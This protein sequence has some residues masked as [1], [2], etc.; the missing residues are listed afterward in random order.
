MA[1]TSS[2]PAPSLAL[3]YKWATVSTLPALLANLVLESK[4]DQALGNPCAIQGLS[5]DIMV[6]CIFPFLCVEEIICLRRVGLLLAF[7]STD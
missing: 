2:L 7:I 6:D 5:T 3:L 1:Y 4:R